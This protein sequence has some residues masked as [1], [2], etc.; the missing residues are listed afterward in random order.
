VDEQRS[1]TAR[2]PSQALDGTGIHLESNV[3]RG[4]AGIYP[5]ER[6]AIGDHL[7]AMLVDESLHPLRIGNVALFSR[8]G[9]HVVVAL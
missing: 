5:R 3:T 6:C 9:S 8:S 2:D 1:A 4:L 7:G